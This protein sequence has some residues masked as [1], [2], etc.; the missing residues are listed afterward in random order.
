MVDYYCIIFLPIVILLNWS[1]HVDA[2]LSV[3]ELVH[4]HDGRMTAANG[5]SR[6]THFWNHDVSNHQHGLEAAVAGGGGGGTIGSSSSLSLSPARH[7]KQSK[8]RKGGSSTHHPHQRQRRPKYYWTE[9]SNVELALREL[10]ES[11]E[12][13]ID[14]YHHLPPIPN[15]SLLNYW[16]RHDLRGAIITHG[17]R[18]LLSERMGNAPIIPGKWNEAVQTWYV[19]QILQ[20][21]RDLSAD[22]PPLSPQRLQQEQKQQLQ[23]QRQRQHE[24]EATKDVLQSGEKCSDN[25][26][27]VLVSRPSR[28]SHS[29]HRK[30]K[31][32]WSSMTVVVEEM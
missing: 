16:N 2:F 9:V 5:G 24:E 14:A 30:P 18:T 1:D 20:H 28:W 8:P 27:E 22:T 17:G 12:V 13:A 10:W 3:R 4:H 6:S 23:Q 15:E 26:N 19:Q 32:Y 29:S 31:G 25:N 21:D 11:K 7:P